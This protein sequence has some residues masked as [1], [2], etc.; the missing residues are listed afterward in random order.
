MTLIYPHGASFAHQVHWNTPRPVDRQ[1]WGILYHTTGRGVPAVAKRT[2]Q[3]PLG[4][5]LDIYRKS[6]DG[7]LHPY[8]W[9]GPTYVMDHAGGLVQ[10]ADERTMTHHAGKKGAR[11]L[12][13]SGKWIEQCSPQMVARWHDRWGPTYRNP[14]QLYPSRNANTDYVGVE[15][16]PCGSGFGTPM[17][18]GLLFTQAQHDTAV[19]LAADLARRHKWAVKEWRTTPRLLGHEDVQPIERHNAGGGWD[20]GA[21]REKPFFDFAYVRNRLAT[22]R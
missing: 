15:M 5:A 19:K 3:S 17:A 18:P 6:Q 16:I 10:I 14:Q 9:G 2:G 21:L 20:P 11:A 7:R 8:L 13:L 4:V 12:Y 22:G 1:P